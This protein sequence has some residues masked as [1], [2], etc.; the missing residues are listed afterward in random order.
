MKDQEA[1][2]GDVEQVSEVE[3]LEEA[4]SA[5]VGHRTQHHNDE[6]N[7]ERDAGWV[8]PSGHQPENVGLGRENPVVVSPHFRVGTVVAQ[9]DLAHVSILFR[10]K[11]HVVLRRATRGPLIHRGQ[12]QEAGSFRPEFFP[13]FGG[14]LEDDCGLGLNVPICG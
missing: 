5:H 8:R 14:Q 12:I 4:A 6:D 1:P 11:G 7:H 9:N 2:I 10:T 3:H 13:V